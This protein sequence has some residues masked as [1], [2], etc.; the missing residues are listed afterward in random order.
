MINFEN[1]GFNIVFE[2]RVV[3]KFAEIVTA[4]IFRTKV[5]STVVFNQVNKIMVIDISQHNVIGC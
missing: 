5:I 4:S 2:H 1:N 3:V